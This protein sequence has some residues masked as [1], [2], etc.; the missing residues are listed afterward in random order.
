MTIQTITLNLPDEIYQRAKHTAEA[1]KRPMEDVIIETLGAVWPPLDDVPPEVVS[2]LSK[3]SLMPNGEL[4]QA[5]RSAMTM[6][7][8]Q[9]LEA[10]NDQQRREGKLLPEERTEQE[11]LLK[12]YGEIILIRAHAAL[13]LKQRGFDVS[14]PEQFASPV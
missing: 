12:N 8:Q 14:D 1:L 9:R 6:A 5:A 11:A 7:Q 3:M 2:K 4:W 13:L 10:L